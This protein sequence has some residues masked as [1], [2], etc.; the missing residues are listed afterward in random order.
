MGK[1]VELSDDTYQQLADLAKQQQRTLEDMLR[2]CLATDE[3]ALYERVHHQMVA[4]GLLDAL[5]TRPLPPDLE[6]CEP[7][8]IPGRPLSESMLED[9]RSCPPLWTRVPW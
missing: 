5:P 6:D 1:V 8:A 7:E 9:R 2:V 4:E 3:A